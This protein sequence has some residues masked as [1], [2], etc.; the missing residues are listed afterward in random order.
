MAKRKVDMDPVTS[1]TN[2]VL[3]AQKT[4]SIEE[5]IDALAKTMEVYMVN[6]DKHAT[7]RNSQSSTGN[8]SKQHKSSWNSYDSWEKKVKNPDFVKWARDRMCR[9]DNDCVRDVCPFKHSTVGGGARTDGV[10]PGKYYASN[11]IDLTN[12]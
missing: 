8:S 2:T 4:T 10:A 3:I 12:L 6:G 7:P 9:A 5:R 11:Q 1:H